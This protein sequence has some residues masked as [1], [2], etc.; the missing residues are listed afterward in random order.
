[1]DKEFTFEARETQEAEEAGSSEAP[2]LDEWAQL[3]QAEIELVVLITES[4]E[5]I[6]KECMHWE[7]K[8]LHSAAICFPK[9]GDASRAYNR[10]TLPFPLLKHEFLKTKESLQPLCTDEEVGRYHHPINLE[11][12][13]SRENMQNQL[14]W[15]LGWFR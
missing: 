2:K 11:Q 9:A 5:P 1:M 14:A 12:W 13:Q 10:P 4:L 3:T 8:I 15:R 6:Q 7:K